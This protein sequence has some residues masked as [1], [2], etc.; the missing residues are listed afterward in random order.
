[1]FYAYSVRAIKRLGTRN[2]AFIRAR[3]KEKVSQP[4]IK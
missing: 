3:L 2:T 1:M 4:S